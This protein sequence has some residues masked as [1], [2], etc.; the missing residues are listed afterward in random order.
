MKKVLF[1]FGIFTS[2]I[3]FAQKSENYY[4][5][6]YN[7]ICCG[8]PSEK[9][10]RDYIQKFQGKNKS[11]TVEIF[12]QTGLGREGEFKLFVGL[13]A[14]SKSNKRKFISGLEAAIN[15]QNTAKGGSDGTVDFMGS[16]MVSKKNLS[17]LPNTTLS[18]KT[19]ITKQKIK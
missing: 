8:P 1:I 15:A 11:K 4:Q 6:S 5:I 13:D 9:P 17:A 10:V 3:F 7:S 14:L 16:S 19:V 18:N 12:K 2:A